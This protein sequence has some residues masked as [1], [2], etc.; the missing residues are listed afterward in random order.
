MH[1]AHAVCIQ[2]HPNPCGRAKR[3]DRWAAPEGFR[4]FP[5]RYV[6]HQMRRS[7]WPALPV[8]VHLAFDGTPIYP[9]FSLQSVSPVL[10]DRFVPCSRVFC[11]RLVRGFVREFL[12]LGF[13]TRVIL[14]WERAW[15][16]E[17]RAPHVANPQS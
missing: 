14:T 9:L 15:V 12:I 1:Y 16:Q 11:S 6:L 4:S 2:G 13:N 5:A 17:Q 3:A 7:R 10:I 8:D